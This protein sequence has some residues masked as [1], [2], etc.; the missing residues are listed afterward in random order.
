MICQKVLLV[1]ALNA[2]RIVGDLRDR[3]SLLAG[4]AKC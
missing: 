1:L 3:R 4:M 2:K